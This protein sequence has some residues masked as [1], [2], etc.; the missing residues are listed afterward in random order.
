MD[1]IYEFLKVIVLYLESIFSGIATLFES[2]FYILGMGSNAASFAWLPSS[3]VSV[4]S[5]SLI[6]IVILRVAGR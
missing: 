6:L 3:V 1:A 5:L 2:F 4:M